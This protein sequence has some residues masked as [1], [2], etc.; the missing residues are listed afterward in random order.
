MQNLPRFIRLI[1]GLGAVASLAVFLSNAEGRPPIPEGTKVLKNLVYEQVDGR[2]MMLDLF[3][4]GNASGNAPLVI[5]IHGGGWENGS[6]QMC[7]AIGL[8]AKGFAV[9]SVDYRLSEQAPFPAQIEDCK[10]AVRWLRAHAAEYHLDSDHFGAWGN[11]TGGH[12][13]SLLGTTGGLKKFEG[14]GGNLDQ[15]SS[16]QAVCS[17]ASP[18][19]LTEM[20]SDERSVDGASMNS[21]PMMKAHEAISSLLRSY[22]DLA[23]GEAEA[24]PITYISKGDPPFL[25]IHGVHDRLVPAHQSERFAAALKKAGVEV[26]LK[27]LPD[28]GHQNSLWTAVPYAE[29]F[30][31]K[32]LQNR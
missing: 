2:S 4:P 27:I 17:V 9:A 5:Y 8:T 1:C 3:L 31:E 15:S 28:L 23:K 13:S 19:D 12:L 11:S 26:T 22:P 16:V 18:S 25:L 7:P 29:S 14:T 21:R 10:A 32:T 30:F 20:A 6:R 24:S